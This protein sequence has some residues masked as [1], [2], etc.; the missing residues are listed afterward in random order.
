MI[1]SLIIV[2]YN[3]A[4]ITSDCLNSVLAHFDP[5]KAEIIVVDNASTDG[6][7]EKFRQ[8][9][10]SRVELV[11]NPANVGFAA[12]NNLGARQAKGDILF[13]LNSDTLIRQDV[14]GALE[15]F[16]AADSRV[17]VAAPILLTGDGQPQ[18]FASGRFP[19]LFNLIF[20]KL[21]DRSGGAGSIKGP[22]KIDWVS[23]AALAVRKDIFQKIGGFDEGFFMY[24][25][26]VDLCRRVKDLG[27]SVAIC[28]GAAVTHLGGKSLGGEAAE[29]KRYYYESQDRFYSKHHGWFISALLRMARFFYKNI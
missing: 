19:G 24:F 4:K 10:G 27:F 28:S 25:E 13:F 21:F 26:D 20:A 14:F 6:S 2:N 17:A 9:F 29:R 1:F 18:P 7:L 5:A 8:E 11:S 15:R 3:T 16:L 12:A 23:G 22:A